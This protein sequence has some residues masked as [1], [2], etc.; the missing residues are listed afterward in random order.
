MSFKDFNLSFIYY[1][2]M[3]FEAFNLSG[4]YYLIISFETFNLSCI[5]Y[6]IMSFILF[7]DRIVSFIIY[8]CKYLIISSL[9]KCMRQKQ[10]TVL[11][12]YYVCENIH[13]LVGPPKGWT[14]WEEEVSKKTC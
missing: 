13:G 9:L 14:D 10:S 5:Y 7:L 8:S 2:I 12:A 11:C 6:L 3:L 1:L 4:F